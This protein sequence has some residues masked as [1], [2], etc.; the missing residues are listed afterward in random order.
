VDQKGR[1]VS[2]EVDTVFQ[3]KERERQEQRLYKLLDELNSIKHY[4]FINIRLLKPLPQINNYSRIKSF[5]INWLNKFDPKIWKNNVETVYEEGNIK[6]EFGLIPKKVIRKDAIVGSWMEFGFS[7]NTSK[8]IRNSIRKKIKTY[9]FFRET[10]SPFIIA[11]CSD[12]SFEVSK[13]LLEW[14]LF[15]KP[16][17][18][19]NKY[20]SDS[21]A[22]FIRDRSGLITPKPAF[23]EAKNKLLSAILWCERSWYKDKFIYDMRIYH[24]PWA[25]TKL[26][27]DI[28]PKLPQYTVVKETSEKIKLG[29]INENGQKIFFPY[30]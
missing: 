26:P 24:N 3:S 6:I 7:G 10:K 5:V 25:Y 9:N 21:L 16:L 8:Q 4:F 1:E 20:Q 14:E 12:G 27:V 13:T 23:G 30:E 15:G 11:L 22:R 19:W 29:W 18:V 2:I 28:F 17:L